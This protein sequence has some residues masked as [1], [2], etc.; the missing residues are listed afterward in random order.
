MRKNDLKLLRHKS[1]RPQ[2]GMSL[3]EL[4][5]A[6]AMGVFFGSVALT[7]LASAGVA[8]TTQD[9]GSRIQ[10]NARFAVEELT[11]NIQMAGYYNKSS[12]TPIE[13]PSGQFFT[14]DCGSGFNPC[15]ADG[16]GTDPDR[17]AVILN[18]PPDDGSDEDCFGNP[19]PLDQ[20]IANLFFIADDENGISSLQ[21]Q[22]FS[23]APVT[24][25]A[26]S[27]GDP[28][29]LVSGVDN[30]QFQYGVPANANLVGSRVERYMTATN[31]TNNAANPWVA[32]KSVQFALLV[33]GGIDE[34]ISD[35]DEQSYD[36]LEVV[37]DEYDDNVLR[38]LITGTVLI[39][40]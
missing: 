5:I 26:T 4:L 37:E 25:V 32:I 18:P 21:C 15:T 1:I 16:A 3:I 31:V 8:S 9:V 35:E 40:N 28:Q 20:V 36:L 34:Q 11:T 29:V 10:E 30:M 13:T 19:V 12:G 24:N 2:T 17:I 6:L 14:G 22:S 33:N 23:I 38:E 39:N 27:L 7:F